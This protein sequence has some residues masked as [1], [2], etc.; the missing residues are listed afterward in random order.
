M[1][2]RP[3][4]PEAGAYANLHMTDCMF[5]SMQDVLCM[6][7]TVRIPGINVPAMPP[8]LSINA[9]KS[10]SMR[11]CSSSVSRQ[12]KPQPECLPELRLQAQQI[13]L[14]WDFTLQDANLV[15]RSPFHFDNMSITEV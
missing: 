3:S 8:P 7:H 5:T 12:T 13:C 2:S 15:Y 1:P 14:A 11:S 4:V 9:F 6:T 10:M